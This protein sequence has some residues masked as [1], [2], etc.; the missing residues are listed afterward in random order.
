MTYYCDSVTR[1]D[2]CRYFSACYDGAVRNL[3]TD[4]A[5][6]CGV[7]IFVG[8]DHRSGLG[9]CYRRWGCSTLTQAQALL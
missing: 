9:D 1:I 7:Y 8:R 2:S 6:C 4:L 3:S 5:E